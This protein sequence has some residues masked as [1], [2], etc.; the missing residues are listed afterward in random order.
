MSFF[1]VPC[2]RRRVAHGYRD[3]TT[4]KWV[5]GASTDTEIQASIQPISGKELLS[6]PE[7]RREREN[8]K[9]YTSSEIREL[10]PETGNADFIIFGGNTYKVVNSRLRTYL[11][12]HYHFE[13][14]KE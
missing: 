12:P 14:M 13:A 7:G 9:G 6:L 3:T 11:L 4:G 5:E 8:I 10:D 2:T 1:N